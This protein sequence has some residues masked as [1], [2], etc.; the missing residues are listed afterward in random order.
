MINTNTNTNTNNNIYLDLWKEVKSRDYNKFYRE[1]EK[2]FNIKI[3]NEIQE[4]IHNL[5]LTTQITIKRSRMLYLH[6]FVLYSSLLNYLKSNKSNISDKSNKPI[7]ILETGTARGFSSLVMA[8]AIDVYLNTM[9][10]ELM[11]SDIPKIYTIDHQ[12][13]FKNGIVMVIQGKHY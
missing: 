8:K 9:D 3:D 13:K 4:F 1:L 10:T 12:M 2:D 7:S 6:G 5:A 11:P